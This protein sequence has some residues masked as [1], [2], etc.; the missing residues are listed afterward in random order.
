MSLKISFLLVFSK[1][2]VSLVGSVFLI[3][4][5]GHICINIMHTYLQLFK[6]NRIV[7]LLNIFDIIHNSLP[8]SSV[9][10]HWIWVGNYETGEECLKS[11]MVTLYLC[12][13]VSFLKAFV[14][15]YTLL[16]ASLK[17]VNIEINSISFSKLFYL[18]LHKRK[19]EFYFCRTP[20]PCLP[21]EYM[22]GN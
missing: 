11:M 3:F 10:M 7:Y 1:T 15:P 6:R 21:C 14:L 19:T 4:R 9:Y 12:L 16:L 20:L 22:F 2:L 18:F 13:I 17:I 8:K 5:E